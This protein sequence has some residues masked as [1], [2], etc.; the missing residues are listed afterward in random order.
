VDWSRFSH[1]SVAG[2]Q[3]LVSRRTV[4][5]A[6]MAVILFQGT[7]IFYEILTLQ[8]V[9][10]R[11]PAAT[12]KVRTTAASIREPADAYRIIPERNLFGTTTKT[13]T[14]KQTAAMPQQDVAL[15][16]ELKGTIAG[17]AQYG[18]AIIEEK[19][20]RKQRLV[21]PGDLVEG[22]KVVRIKRNA[23]DLL[24]GDQTRTL[25]I[26]ETTEGPILPPVRG[27]QAQMTSP[28]P[29]GTTVISRSEVDRELQDM[30]NLLRQAQI[31]PFFN[32]GVPDGF[33]I[34]NIRSGS[35]YQ[36]MG[37]TDGDVIQQVNNRP[38]KTA[39]DMTWLLNSL[40][41]GSN[42]SLTVKRRGKQ[43]TMN[44]QFQ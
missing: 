25:K 16:I 14:E 37:I 5:L 32:A 26:S 38:I 6:L 33:M 3:G 24:V 18:F 13:V 39:E 2:F 7:G 35:I 28:A 41:S 44:Y 15:L 27:V 20:T 40:N 36:R 10:M 12:E 22:A 34:S 19:G 42:L 30:G 1:I 11:P 31:R 17:D 23:I 4:T 21:K 29:A 9:R 43:E 8:L